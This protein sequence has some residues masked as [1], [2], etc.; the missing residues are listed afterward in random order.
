MY[1]NYVV[2]DLGRKNG[3]QGNCAVWPP[4]CTYIGMQDRL[5]IGYLMMAQAV[6]AEVA[7]V[8]I[9]WRLV[10]SI[11][12]TIELYNPDQSH[13]SL[14]GSY[15]AACTFYASIYHKS[16]VG[17]F[18]PAAISAGDALIIQQSAASVV[19]DSLATWN[20]DTTTVRSSFGTSVSGN[21]ELTFNNTTQNATSYLWDFGD[22]TTS[23]MFSPVHQYSQPGSWD[24][25]LISYRGCESD[26]IMQTVLAVA[27]PGI[28]EIDE[29]QI[30]L[31][32]NPASDFI[33]IK[34]DAQIEL[35]LALKLFDSETRLVKELIVDQHDYQLE[36]GELATGNYL[37]DMSSDKHTLSKSIVVFR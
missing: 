3:D 17:A 37:L 21:F 26:T 22:G 9:V 12:P 18:H 36:L 29:S 30:E 19:F 6:D 7:P 16:P 23:D 35:P 34:L 8:G 1:N 15:L 24:V 25:T 11:A 10:R 2:Y 28:S 32:P 14:T 13:P 33:R 5:R 20:I 31:Y 27:T 4:V